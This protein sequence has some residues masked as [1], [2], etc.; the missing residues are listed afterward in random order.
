MVTFWLQLTSTG[1]ADSIALTGTTSGRE[2][3]RHTSISSD[4]K[5]LGVDNGHDTGK[6]KTDRN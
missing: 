1:I 4:A 5:K 2:Q 3:H 6:D